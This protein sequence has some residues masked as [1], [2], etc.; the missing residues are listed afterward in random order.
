MKKLLAAKTLL[1]WV[2]VLQAWANIYADYAIEA[3]ELYVGQVFEIKVETIALKESQKIYFDFKNG[4]NVKILNPLDPAAQKQDIK[5]TYTFLAKA[6]APRAAMHDIEI[7]MIDDKSVAMQKQTL[8]GQKLQ[9]TRLNPPEHFSGVLA[10]QLQLES[11]QTSVFD[12]NSNIVAFKLSASRANL[13]DFALSGVNKQEIKSFERNGR[14]SMISYYAI[15]DKSAQQLRFSY[16]DLAQREYETISVPI[17]IIRD[18][19]STQTQLSP[20]QSKLYQLKLFL[21]ISTLGLLLLILIFKRSYWLLA[22]AVAVG[23]Y[24]Y[25]LLRPFADV[26]LKEESVVYILPT[27]NATAIVK[28]QN[29]VQVKKL[30]S[31]REYVKVEFAGGMIGWVLQKDIHD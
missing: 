18:S 4:F 19:V 14:E 6:T 27:E 22:I 5:T 29:P 11:F 25:L 26:E 31:H 2:F 9:A 30:D 12:E 13:G 20:Q 24:L 16:F 10:K 7:T 21:S 1:L 23:I 17:A 3:D 8:E 28:N 15:V